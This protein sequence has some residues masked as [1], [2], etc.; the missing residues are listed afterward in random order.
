MIIVLQIFICDLLTSKN[1]GG[2]ILPS[3]NV[4]KVIVQAE[5]VLLFYTDNLK[6]LNISNLE[7]KTISSC[8]NLLAL[9]N[10][11]FS[12]LIYENIW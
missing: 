9:N 5:K 4:F 7:R 3:D 8:N 2:L 10:N 12:D 6:D 1:R 11:I